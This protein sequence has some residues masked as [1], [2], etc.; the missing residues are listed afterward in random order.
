MTATELL[1]MAEALEIPEPIIT[2]SCF[3]F[4]GIEA[5]GLTLVCF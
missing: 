2:P 4:D 3:L 5:L 1:N